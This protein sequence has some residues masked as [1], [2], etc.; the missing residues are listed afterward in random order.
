MALDLIIPG[1]KQRLRLGDEKNVVELT[2][3][4]LHMLS[5]L[6]EFAQK[7]QLTIVCKRCN[8]SMGGVNSDSELKAGKAPAVACQCREWRYRR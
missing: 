6:H 4:E 1:Q 8:H 5:A 7:Y 3:P 2:T